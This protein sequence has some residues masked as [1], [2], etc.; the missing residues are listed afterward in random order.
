MLKN[1]DEL[2][3]L[4]NF[5]LHCVQDARTP[6]RHI[7]ISCECLGDS[8]DL[9]IEVYGIFQNYTAWSECA[10]FVVT[11]KEMKS[12]CTP[13]KLLDNLKIRFDEVMKTID[14][15]AERMNWV[16]QEPSVEKAV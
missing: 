11:G 16:S 1:A 3:E 14:E 4:V 9:F 8:D 10:S 2:R 6:L 13:E 7:N 12:W 5:T 15:E